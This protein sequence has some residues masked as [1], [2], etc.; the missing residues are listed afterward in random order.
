MSTAKKSFSGA[1]KLFLVIIAVAAVLIVLAAVG[2]AFKFSMAVLSFMVMG[3][4]VLAGFAIIMGIIFM[5]VIN[6]FRQ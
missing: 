3:F 1:V 6:K 2:L 5:I 4:K